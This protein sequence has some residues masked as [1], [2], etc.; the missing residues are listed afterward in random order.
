MK[1]RKKEMKKFSPH[2]LTPEDNDN[3]TPRFL[4]N[5]IMNHLWSDW[6]EG[7]PNDKFWLRWC[8]YHW[9]KLLGMSYTEIY[10][11]VNKIEDKEYYDESNAKKIW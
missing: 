9:R 5:K 6:D 11:K 3:S 10:S 4:A 7:S 8:K 1:E 2:T